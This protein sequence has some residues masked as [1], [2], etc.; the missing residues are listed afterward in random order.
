MVQ[1]IREGVILAS[2]KGE[3]LSKLTGNIP[4]CFYP[5]IGKNSLIEF[6]LSA[7]TRLGIER[8]IVIVPPKIKLHSEKILRRYPFKEKVVIENPKVELGNAFSF[9]KTLE[10]AKTDYAFVSCCDTIYPH[11]FLTELE[12]HKEEAD[13]LIAVSKNN[14]YVEQEEASKVKMSVNGE[15]IDIGKHVE[16][17]GIIDTGVFLVRPEPILNRAVINTK[18]ETHLYQLIG[19]LRGKIRIK[20]I[21]VNDPWTEIDT[22]DN[23][24]ELL[25]GKRRRVLDYF[26]RVTGIYGS[27]KEK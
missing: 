13:L 27:W 3:R 9:L 5:L 15:I 11:T 6:S 25:E 12:K 8:I 2:G 20:G 26:E 17:T 24:K 19:Q 22:P 1:T 14:D 4:K 18:R 23:L 16:N 10:T 7:Y 21:L